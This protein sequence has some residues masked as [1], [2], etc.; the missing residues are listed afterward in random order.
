MSQKDPSG[1]GVEEAVRE[2][3]G[4]GSNL[5]AV[6]DALAE[7]PPDE[8]A[9]ALQHFEPE[10][11]A[12][13][14]EYVDPTTAASIIRELDTQLAAA[15]VQAMRRPEAAVVL[16][17]MQP[18]DRVDVIGLIPQPLHDELMREL[19]PAQAEEVRTLEQYAPDT[20]GGIMT[21]NYTSLLESLTVEEAVGRLREL[22]QQQRVM[23]YAYV[24]DGRDHLVGVLSMR[25]LVLASPQQKLSDIMI[26]RVNSVAVDADQEEVARYMK[27]HNFM[28]LP[29]VDKQGKLVGMITMDDAVDVLDEEATEDV[30]RMA[31]AGAEERLTSKWQFSFKKRIWWLEVNLATA[32]L[33]GAVVGLFEDVISKMAV[34][35][36]YM[37]II[38]GMG[39][40]A[41]AQA[42]AV[43]IR[44]I[45]RGEVDR[46]MLRRVL[47]R[48]A[49]V[50]LVTGLLIGATTAVIA[51][52]FQGGS[53]GVVLGA[54]VAVALVINHVAACTT[55]VFVP[56]VMK[57]MGFD[58]AQSA[59]IFATTVTDVVGFFALLGLAWMAMPWLVGAG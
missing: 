4:I 23:F 21:L 8:A 35:A 55:G 1:V 54:I 57:S 5:A 51:M 58:P 53:T 17:R 6:A 14:A 49:I 41:G 36:I 59:T 52:I 15:V 31:G 24:V 18:D 48:E 19:S 29:V 27:S 38:A 10:D 2:E 12:D 22:R 40:N 11:A 16:G 30:Q 9:R 56:F 3:P 42:M 50:G 26:T 33:A 43:A 7:L 45:S 20:A 25:D 34:L 28:A 39:G 46:R 47:W 32:F 13:I 44:G 37:P